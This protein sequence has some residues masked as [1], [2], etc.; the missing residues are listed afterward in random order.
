MMR[1]N[2]LKRLL[3]LWFS[4]TVLSLCFIISFAQPALPPHS[5]SATTSNQINATILTPITLA[6]THALDF[7]LMTVPSGI[8]N[9]TL[10]TGTIR[11]AS[12]PANIGLLALAPFPATAAYSVS[13]S[14]S[15][16]YV[17][18]LPPDNTVT[19][20]Q[21]SNPMHV[22][23]FIAKTASAGVDGITGT[24]DGSGNDNFVVGATLKL[25]NGQ[26]IGTYTGTFDVTVSYN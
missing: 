7:G 21:G 18:S 10:T 24:L 20:T 4:T 1:N 25:A 15:V 19:I 22:D 26:P 9:V 13:G 5:N 6:E 17:I 3:K 8:V 23:G 11:I 14:A 2:K 16:N 12:I